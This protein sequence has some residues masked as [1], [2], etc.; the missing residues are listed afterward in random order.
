MDK[1]KV[2]LKPEALKQKPGKKE[3]V[4]GKN[5]IGGSARNVKNI[6]K[7]KAV[8]SKNKQ[9]QKADTEAAETVESNGAAFA[10]TVYDDRKRYIKNKIR[11]HKIKSK[12][13]S[14][15][16]GVNGSVFRENVRHKSE[17]VNGENYGDKNNQPVGAARREYVEKKLRTMAEHRKVY[18]G[19]H[20]ASNIH[21]EYVKTKKGANILNHRL[22]NAANLPKSEV[23]KIVNT[24]T[25]YIGKYVE[26]KYVRAQ[27][28]TVGAKKELIRKT[29]IRLAKETTITSA[30]TA[31]AAKRAAVRIA[32]MVAESAQAI[33]SAL[34]ALG[35]WAVLL[36]VLISVIIVAAISASPFGLFISEEAAGGE[37]IPISSI[38]NECNI[39]LTQK[40]ED[41]ENGQE[42]DSIELSGEPADWRLVLSLFS[43]KIAGREDNA[44]EDA[45]II[46]ERKEQKLKKAFWDMHRIASDTETTDDGK[47]IL[48]ITISAK[49]KEE[50][51]EEYAFTRKQKEALE[52]LLENADGFIGAAQSLAISDETAQ[53]VLERL[54]EN[55]PEGRKRVVKNACSL[56]GKVNYF[57]GG[58]SSAIGWDS[59]WGKMKRVTAPGSRSTG[60]IRPFGLDCSGFV[61]WSF[62]NSGYMAAQI[63]HGAATQATK[64]TRISWTAATPGDLAL[65]SDNSHIGIIA[66]RDSN[67]NVIVIHCASGANNVV[68]TTSRGFGYVV[69]P[70]FYF[71]SSDR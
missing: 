19:E 68:I 53:Q 11:E 12:D 31:T 62:I 32:H 71:L 44:A 27:K 67:G 25:P 54:P 18:D 23:R 61:T 70:S 63:G 56:V 35:G 60:T 43:V 55:L 6:M 22:S 51:I 36:V 40:L 24:E 30:R 39:E 29:K 26:S 16:S 8:R 47:R 7:E 37:S 41:I 69:R 14:E 64:G 65:Y 1:V 46:D 21:G 10:D 5:I 58:K 34:A 20:S 48:H 66:G 49:T 57:W 28:K 50:M 59:G 33:V 2:K 42:Y 4:K 9:N 15:K 17:T 45:V 13:N 52:T 38:V 3:T